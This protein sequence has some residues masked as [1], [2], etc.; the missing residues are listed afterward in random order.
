[1]P[2]PALLL[3]G[4]G[5]VGSMAA[6]NAAAGAQTAAAQSGI[7]EQRRQFDV[8]R[9]L[10]AP[11]VSAG[12]TGLSAQMGLLGLSGADAQQNAIA[13]I[14]AGPE[15]G[16]LTQAGEQAILSNASATGGLRGGNTQA[17]L[18]QFRPQVLSGLINQRLDRYGGL[19]AMG[20]NSAAGV[21]AAAQATGGNIAQLMQQQ[22]AAA[23]GGA[24][25]GG[26]AF[27][28]L[29]G[30]FGQYVGRFGNPAGPIGQG[31]SWGF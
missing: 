9:G 19:A 17:A 8:V 22:G 25:A 18:A 7:D 1:M 10:L 21:G 12:S 4:L 14:Q 6:A 26:Q 29:L 27:G 30:G 16:A 31:S 15:F 2:G 24:L 13:G 23:A 3:G 20:Q 28:N 11:Y 5:A